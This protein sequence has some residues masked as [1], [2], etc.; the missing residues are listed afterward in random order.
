[1]NENKNV[2]YKRKNGLNFDENCKK[3]SKYVAK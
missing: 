2:L 1:M 3:Y